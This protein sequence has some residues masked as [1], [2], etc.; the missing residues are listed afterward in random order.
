MCAHAAPDCAYAARDCAYAARDCAYAA[1]DCAI[2]AVP[3][4]PLLFA[5]ARSIYPKTKTN[6]TELTVTLNRAR[7]VAQPRAQKHLF[8]LSLAQ[9][10]STCARHP[11]IL[12]GSTNYL[13]EICLFKFQIKSSYERTSV[14]SA[15]ARVHV[16]QL[17]CITA[18]TAVQG[19]RKS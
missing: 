17:V 13:Y 6:A 9:S 15:S 19:N 14:H 8:G 1:R 10:Q 12:L 18:V 2:S 5:F 7:P 16:S 3:C 4:T 11:R